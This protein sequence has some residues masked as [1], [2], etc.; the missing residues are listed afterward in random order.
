MIAEGFFGHYGPGGQTPAD[1]LREAGWIRS[2]SVGYSI[3]ENIAWGTGRFASPQAIVAAWM[4]SPPHRANILD[5][6]FEATGIGVQAGVPGS[7]GEGR[8][9]AT[10]TEDFGVII[11]G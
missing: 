7:L 11:A 2:G 10:Y 4:S 6:E 9:G 1:R 3:G 5:A 8:P